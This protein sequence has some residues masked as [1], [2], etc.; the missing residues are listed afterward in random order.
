MRGGPLFRN[1]LGESRTP[2]SADM[3]QGGT[4][5][6]VLLIA[7]LVLAPAVLSALAYASPPDPAW[8]RGIYDDGDFDNVVVLITSAT[9]NLTLPIPSAPRPVRFSIPRLPPR[10]EGVVSSSHPLD[11]DPRAP[12]ILSGS[13]AA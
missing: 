8:I 9:G 5:S 12:P 11:G 10:D 13:S 4:W 1:S 3:R 7:V 6:R 2:G